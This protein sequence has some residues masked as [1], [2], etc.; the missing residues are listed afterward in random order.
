MKKIK[1]RLL[2]YLF[3]TVI[4]LTCFAGILNDNGRA[5]RTGSPGSNPCTTSCHSS[6]ALNSGDGSITITCDN[7]PNWNYEP[8]TVYTI[9]VT[10]QKPNMVIFGLG[11]EALNNTSGSVF[12]TIGSLTPGN[13]TQ[14]KFAP[15]SGFSRQNIVHL[16]N[17]G[18]TSNTKT[19]TFTW[20]SP[21]TIPTNSTITFYAAGVAGNNNN[22]NSGDYVYTAN[23]EITPLNTAAKINEFNEPINFN[24]YPMPVESVLNIDIDSA[25][26]STFELYNLEGKI[27]YHT[28]LSRNVGKTYTIQLPNEIFNG[29]Y[30]A[31]VSNSKSSITKRI[32]INK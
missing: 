13:D 26:E 22:S 6:F 31:K 11:F 27:V 23:Q 15:V 16:P 9:N 5:G 8:N 7:M 2:T 19:F 3:C 10:V 32:I 29:I 25:T 30:F 20:T 12:E 28:I 24:L 18:L 14:I 21:S 17:G 4:F 1:T